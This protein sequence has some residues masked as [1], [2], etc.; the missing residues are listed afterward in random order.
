MQPFPSLPIRWLIASITLIL[1]CVSACDDEALPTLD[2]EM[3]I[4]P[5]D[6]AT[7]KPARQTDEPGHWTKSTLAIPVDEDDLQI[8]S[9]NKEELEANFSTL[10]LNVPLIDKRTNE[11]CL[12][13]S[14][15]AEA[16]PAQSVPRLL[17]LVKMRGGNFDKTVVQVDLFTPQRERIHH[18]CI[19]ETNA[20]TGTYYP[21]EIRRET[22]EAF[23]D[24]AR[25]SELDTIIVGLELNRY[26][27]LSGMSNI[28]RAF[29]YSN[30]MNLYREIYR[31]IKEQNSSIRVGPSISWVHLMSTTVPRV[32]AQY[33]LD[34]DEMLTLELALRATVWPLLSDGDESTAD[35]IGVTI[36]PRSA[37]PPYLNNAAT[38]DAAV[39]RYYRDLPL[40]AS[41]P[42][43]EPLPL[44]ITQLD[45]ITLNFAT[46][47]E[48]SDFLKSLKQSISHVSFD[49]V[50]WRRLSNLLT[51]PIDKCAAAQN[52]GHSADFCY[53][54][55]LTDVGQH[56]KVW[57]EFTQKPE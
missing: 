16:L 15:V 34:V 43:R 17:N 23:K 57:D 35:L 42:N 39:K 33:E 12:T 3:T 51:S 32:A 22:L 40:I 37:E 54:G 24:L 47:G 50:A 5:I 48:K 55:L 30:L 21:D 38:E 27:D 9:S 36:I 1:T 10:V 31:V 28:N 29:D 41:P 13:G 52:L 44:A 25:L 46:G 11:A 7:I 56:R 53:A 14:R 20:I 18:Q 45:W 26:P 2:L 4:L 8:L 49:W 6:E 19:E